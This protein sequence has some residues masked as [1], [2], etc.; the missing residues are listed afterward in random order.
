MS[1]RFSDSYSGAHLVGNKK[2][3]EL[4]T[5]LIPKVLLNVMFYKMTKY[6]FSSGI[7]KSWPK[8]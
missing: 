6:S 8:K 4:R 7:L 1:K 2:K 3:P 5:I